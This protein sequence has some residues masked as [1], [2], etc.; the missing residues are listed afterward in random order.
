MAKQLPAGMRNNNPGNIKYVGQAGTTPSANLDQGDPQA[1]FQTPEA[2]MSAMYRLLLKKYQGGKV[3]PMAMIAGKGGWT[4]G[5]T[6]AAANVARYAGIG[7]NDDIRLTDPASAAKF[8]RALMLQEHGEASRAYTDQQISAAIGGGGTYDTATS[9]S[10]YTIAGPEGKTAQTQGPINIR[11]PPNPAAP[12]ATG[13][14]GGYGLP[15]QAAPE[16]AVA[17]A[18]PYALKPED[19]R[20]QKG[21]EMMAQSIAGMGGQGQNVMPAM[22]GPAPG[23]ARVDQPN[24]PLLDPQQNQMQ[25]QQLAA[26]LARLNSGALV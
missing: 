26:I 17:S 6:A 1:V 10:P 23:A 19:F 11:H 8:M 3:S 21:L 15:P 20:K 9:T 12:T 24:A 4:P 5:N 18:S 13:A 14:I 7:P 2:G 22:T 25:R 16:T